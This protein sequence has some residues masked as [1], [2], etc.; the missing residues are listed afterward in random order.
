MTEWT[1]LDVVFVAGYFFAAVLS[2]RVILML[3]EPLMRF[4]SQANA[5]PP[6]VWKWMEANPRLSTIAG[7]E[8]QKCHRRPDGLQN[9]ESWIAPI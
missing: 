7:L 4:K 9:G 3:I 6:H 1:F 2:M 8:C 5:C